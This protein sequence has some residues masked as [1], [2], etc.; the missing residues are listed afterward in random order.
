MKLAI[1]GG[2]NSVLTNWPRDDVRFAASPPDWG[3]PLRAK[4][5]V[6]SFA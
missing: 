3:L 5:I 6:R 1:I 2:P 4:A